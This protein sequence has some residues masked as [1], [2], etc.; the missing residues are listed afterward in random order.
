MG[1]N[2]IAIYKLGRIDAAN[3]NIQLE[4]C[5]RLGEL[6]VLKLNRPFV[7]DENNGSELNKPFLHDR[8]HNLK[9]TELAQTTRLWL[10]SVYNSLRSETRARYY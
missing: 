3:L 7:G 5:F 2:N 4:V 9:V 6:H 8:L 10:Q 1:R